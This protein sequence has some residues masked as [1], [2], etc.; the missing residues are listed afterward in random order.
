MLTLNEA[1]RLQAEREKKAVIRFSVLIAVIVA[2]FISVF[3]F[4]DYFQKYP[5]LLYAVAAVS[6]AVSCMNSKIYRFFSPKEFT[7]TVVYINT[8]VELAKAYASHQPGV[9]YRTNE[10]RM[11]EMIVDNGK[12][13]VR[14][15][16]EYD[17]KWGEFR[18]GQTVALLRFIDRPI[19]IAEPDKKQ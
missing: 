5:A 2:A 1:R 4:T 3:V 12:K 11:L 7:G 16:T 10:I 19:L 13:T 18:E 14:K 8:S 6:F 9:K 15:N 17:L